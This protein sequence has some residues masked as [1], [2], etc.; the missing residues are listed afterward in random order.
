M[1]QPPLTRSTQDPTT[2][3][4]PPWSLLLLGPYH[5]ALRPKLLVQRSRSDEPLWNEVA[6][7]WFLGAWPAKPDDLPPSAHAVLDVTAELPR[8]HANLAYACIRVWDTHAPSVSDLTRAV[9]W[10]RTQHAKGGVYIHCAH[11]H[12]RSAAM[13]A[14]CLLDAGAA[15]SVD[16]AVA[17]MQRARPRARLNG[18]QRKAVDEWWGLSQAGKKA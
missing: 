16:G 5:A 1:H 18:R 15:S 17:L 13:L 7:K 9:D 8:T 14:A 11:G 4:L 6:E 3:R 10:A 2:G 12:G